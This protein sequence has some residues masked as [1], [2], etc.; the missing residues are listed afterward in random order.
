MQSVDDEEQKVPKYVMRKK[1]EMG[2][3]NQFDTEDVNV[4]DD[5]DENSYEE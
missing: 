5:E 2:P 3:G 1:G 4:D